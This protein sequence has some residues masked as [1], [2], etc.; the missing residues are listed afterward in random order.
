MTWQRD[1]LM[2][3]IGWRVGMCVCNV[4]DDGVIDLCI[5]RACVCVYIYIHTHTIHAE[6]DGRNGRFV[7]RSTDE[8]APAQC[9]VDDR[10]ERLSTTTLELRSAHASS[11]L[12]PSLLFT[13]LFLSLSLLFP[14]KNLAPADFQLRY[15]TSSRLSAFLSSDSLRVWLVACP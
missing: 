6:W 15:P 3:I 1:D 4:Y 12:S 9:K 11:F 13:S 10:G 7:F 5:L 2:I 8:T 14:F